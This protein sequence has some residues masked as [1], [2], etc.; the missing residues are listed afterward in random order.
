MKKAMETF[1]ALLFSAG[2]CL[3]ASDSDWMPL[4]NIAGLLL[5]WG[6]SVLFSARHRRFPSIRYYFDAPPRFSAWRPVSG[7]KT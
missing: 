5:M 4:P 2:L 1:L 7:E 6:S 3:A